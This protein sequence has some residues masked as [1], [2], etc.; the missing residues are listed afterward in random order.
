[1]TPR[2]ITLLFVFSYV[3][4]LAFC[5][6]TARPI[7][8]DKE[9]APIAVWDLEDVSPLGEARPDLGELL[10]SQIIET[11][12]NQVKYTVV[13]RERFLLALEEL[14]LGTTSLVDD[15]TRLK[16]GRI[17]GAKLMVF[18]GYQII[19]DFMRLDLRLVEVETGKTLK[20][21][22]KTTPASDLTGML[23][24]AQSVAE[25]LL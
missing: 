22:A 25:E 20:A 3:T 23:G 2:T 17:V 19:G 9:N 12:K 13:E 10:S 7:L 5:G 4:L 11:F 14:G 8:N 18:G 21:V 16:L 24:V 15:N 6:G 1:M